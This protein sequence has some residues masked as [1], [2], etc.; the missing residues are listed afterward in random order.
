ML[1]VWFGYRF[2]LILAGII[3]LERERGPKLKACLLGIGD[4]LRSRLDRSF[5]ALH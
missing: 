4:G 5:E 2:S 3:L 1:L